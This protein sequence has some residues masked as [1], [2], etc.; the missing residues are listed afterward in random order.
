VPLALDVGLLGFREAHC[1][2]S[3]HVQWDMPNNPTVATGVSLGRP[4][5][6]PGKNLPLEN[7]KP[8]PP[9]VLAG[10]VSRRSTER[11]GQSPKG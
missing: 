6:S 4:G 9:N 11:L 5:F 8:L 7:T 3:V 1:P 2:V 10:R